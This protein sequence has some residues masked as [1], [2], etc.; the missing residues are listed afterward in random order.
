MTNWLDDIKLP[1][2]ISTHYSDKVVGTK[3]SGAIVDYGLRGDQ[4]D[5]GSGYITKGYTVKSF[6][7][8]RKK[9]ATLKMTNFYWSSYKKS[10]GTIDWDRIGLIDGIKPDRKEPF[11]KAAQLMYDYI[12]ENHV[13]T[14]VG[15]VNFGAVIFPIIKRV[16]ED[17][18]CDLEDPEKFY[19]YCLSFTREILPHY[20]NIIEKSKRER[21]DEPRPCIDIEAQLVADLVKNVLKIL[22]NE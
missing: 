3:F 20:E 9:G 19:D 2:T 6:K 18:N 15:N 10:D 11:I 8:E 22:N 17:S 21:N 1:K 5:E 13:I 4:G 7:I 16:I 14:Q 12:T